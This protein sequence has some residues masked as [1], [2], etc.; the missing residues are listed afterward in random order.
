MTFTRATYNNDS[1]HK[2]FVCTAT[3]SYGFMLD[4]ENVFCLKLIYCK[5]LLHFEITR[6]KIYLFFAW[7]DASY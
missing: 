6:E 3:A 5:F 4:L 1:V 2:L 7:N